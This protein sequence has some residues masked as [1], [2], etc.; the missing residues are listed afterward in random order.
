MRR[1]STRQPGRVHVALLFV[2]LA[3]ATLYL[4]HARAR[5]GR[6]RVEYEGRERGLLSRRE[7]RHALSVGGCGA[8][9]L[10]ARAAAARRVDGQRDILEA[11]ASFKDKIFLSFPSVP[12]DVKPAGL[13]N[14]RALAARHKLPQGHV[15]TQISA[16][17]SAQL[18]V[19]GLKRAGRDLSREKFIGALEGLYE[20]E[21][22]LT[23]PL[24]YGPNR[25]VGAAGA[26]IVSVDMEKKQFVPVSGWVG[27]K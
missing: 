18:L 3:V 14:L 12:S 15:A 8:S 4:S 22:G 2:A 21:T 1:N 10:V 13:E 9:E 24:T 27:I 16:Y 17:V 6:E 23:P 25:R 5:G 19:E 7:R 11:P 26:Y 20:Y